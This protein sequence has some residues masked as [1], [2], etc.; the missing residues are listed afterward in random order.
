MLDRLHQSDS[1]LLDDFNDLLSSKNI[2]PNLFSDVPYYQNVFKI[3]NWEEHNIATPN[4]LNRLRI[5]LVHIEI[6]YLEEYLKT[7]SNDL[8]A[9]DRL[10]RVKVTLA[11]L[12]QY[13][14]HVD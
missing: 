3:R 9:R 14:I 8:L 5:D 11:E 10:D 12:A 2:D 4:F 7:N 13:A 1:K 6:K